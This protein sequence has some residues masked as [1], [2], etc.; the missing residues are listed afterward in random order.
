MKRIILML[1][2]LSL[3]VACPTLSPAQTEPDVRAA[4]PTPSPEISAPPAR[5]AAPAQQSGASQAP[6][7]GYKL[8][9]DDAVRMQVFGEPELTVEQVV[10]PGGYITIPLIGQVYAQDLTQAELAEAIK[11]GISK[12]LVDPKIQLTLSQIRPARVYVL[13]Q[14]NRPGPVEYKPGQRVMEAVA[15]AGSFTQAADLREATLT[16]K[17]SEE[18]MPIN[19]RKLFFDG[20]MSQ[21]IPL[22]DGDTVFIPEDT[23][24][25]YFVLGEV[26]RPMMYRWTDNITIMEAI[27]TA[28]G[29]TPRASLKNTYVVRGDPKN[30][31]RIKVDIG[32]L[33]KKADLSQ[34]LLLQPGDVVYVAESSKPDWS[35]IG[36]ILSVVVNSSYLFRYWGL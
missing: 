23:K 1:L 3:L 17:G 36:N 19:L 31:Q 32:E 11:K 35:K 20:D 22:K 5:P 14:V 16:P 6:P 10:N 29:P 12:Y 13:G 7:E 25:K 30:P 21:N 18:S 24:N 2:S 34:N 33:V 15:S 4:N 9:P 27:T 28:G 8:Q 26:L